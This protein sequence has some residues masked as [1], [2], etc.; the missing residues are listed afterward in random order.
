MAFYKGKKL[1]INSDC[2]YSG[3]WVKDCAKTLDGLSIPSC[4]HHTK[5]K[6]VLFN[7]WS[8]CDVNENAT[9]LCYVNEAI[10]FDETNKTVVTAYHKKLSSG[11]TTK[12]GD[13]RQ[14]RCNKVEEETCAVDPTYTWEDQMF[15]ESASPSSS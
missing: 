9:A 2:S 10:A 13:F 11:Q 6:K 15:H 3:N 4:G 5:E 8:S 12:L 1:T 7:I 14:I